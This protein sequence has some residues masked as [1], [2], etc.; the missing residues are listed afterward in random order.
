MTTSATTDNRYTVGQRYPFIRLRFQNVPFSPVFLPWLH[1]LDEIQLL[2]VT[3]KSAHLV[4]SEWDSDDVEPKYT[5]YIFVDDSGREWYNQYPRYSCGQ[6]TDEGRFRISPAEPTEE[7][8]FLNYEQT[9]L[10]LERILRG[11]KADLGN[12]D[13]NT[14]LQAHY[15][16]VVQKVTAAGW[17]VKQSPRIIRFTNGDPPIEDPTRLEVTIVQQRQST[18]ASE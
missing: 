16:E 9:E 8:L 15:D 10:F 5:G 11:V 14:Q 6:I 13:Y 1:R 12:S 7:E 3:C 18:T 4:R 2:E 17:E